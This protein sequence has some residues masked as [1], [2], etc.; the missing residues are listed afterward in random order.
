MSQP[1]T[2]ELKPLDPRLLEQ[3]ADFKGLMADARFTR[4]FLPWLRRRRLSP[5]RW[6]MNLRR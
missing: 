3:L 4:S 1:E 5:R 6:P 2:E